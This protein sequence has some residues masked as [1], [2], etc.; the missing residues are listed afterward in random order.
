MKHFNLRFFPHLLRAGSLAAALGLLA[1][2]VA[3][4]QVLVYQQ[5][6]DNPV[7]GT[8]LFD[9]S[10]YYNGNVF[11]G[12]PSGANFD[13]NFVGDGL[14]STSFGGLTPP[15]S[16]YFLIEQTPEG[17]DYAGTVFSTAGTTITIL[18]QSTYRLSF[19]LGQVNDINPPTI[20]PFINGVPLSGSVSPSAVNVMQRFAF[21][22]NSGAA[23][24]AV[25]VLN[26]NTSTGFGN[27]FAID[28]IQL[29]LVQTT[30]PLTGLTP[31]QAAVARNLNSGGPNAVSTAVTN[32][33]V[34]NPSAYPGILDQ[35]SPEEFGRFTSITAFN[36]ASFEVEAMDNYLAGE[37]GGP[38]G[39]FIG[40]NG[41]IDASG[42]TLNDPSYDPNL[43][44]V[45]SRLMAWNPGPL[46]GTVSDIANPVLGGVDMKD[47]K[48]MK[49][50]SGPAY[51]NPWNFFVRG[52]VVLAQGFSQT[53]VGHFDENTES[54]IVG[55][56]YRITPNFLV[57]LKAGYGHTDV[58]LDN[59][60]SSATVDSY[61]SGL[62][63]SYADKGWYANVI[64]D[65][66]HNAYTQARDIGF[67]DQTA[68]S[69]PEGNEGTAD[70]DGGYDFHL[71]A[72]AYGPIAG[73]QYTHL[74][75]D[76]YQ[77]SDS[78]ADL[79]VDDQQ[80]DSLRSRLGARISYACSHYGMTFRPHL[81]ATWQ[82]EFMDQ[83]RGITSQFDGTGLGSFSVRTDNP[84]RD[85]AMATAGLDANVN[86]TVTAFAEYMVQAGQDNY[87]GQSVQAGVRIGF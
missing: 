6:F 69:S 71:G 78:V 18:P 40:G 36:D 54:V 22:Y 79:S 66:L 4:A 61:S 25:I 74:T 37:H 62:Y 43:A 68:N 10:F 29:T 51:T 27:D 21:D 7:N 84:Q 14:L 58:T 57:G 77:E 38:N 86:Q 72:L 34:A 24:N 23:T 26:N 63:A 87:F 67:L 46:N 35:L 33:L 31:N 56:D 44:M 28:S 47:S 9:A 11:T 60:G 30:L 45:H 59:N 64:G 80:D 19:Y 82:H 52:N 20:Q 32:A 39:T 3:P 70:L 73:V 13:G 55:T 50:T 41:G 81:D 12:L 49:S 76:G 42:L 15:S 53:D 8:V 85:F 5:N 48:D 17:P 2:G 16:P 65:Y 1:A 83:G 75:V